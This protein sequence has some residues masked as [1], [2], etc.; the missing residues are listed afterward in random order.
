[1]SKTSV[2]ITCHNYGQYLSWCINSV[3]HQTRKAKEIIVVDDNSDDIT[4]EVAKTFAG[5]I[6]YFKVAFKNSQNARNFGLSQATGEYVLFLDADDFL[7]NYA[8]ETMERELYMNPHL[9]LVYSDKCVFGDPKLIKALNRKFYWKSPEFDIE[10]LKYTNFISLPAL[11][12]KQNF[13]G[14]DERIQ[15]LQD[16]EA[17]LNCLESSAD[18]KRVPQPLFYYRFHG[19]NKTVKA[20]ECIA[21]LKIL[22]KHDLIRVVTGQMANYEGTNVIA[23]PNDLVVVAHNP[24][25]LNGQVFREFILKNRRHIKVFYW[26]G[27]ESKVRDTGALDSLRSAGI[28]CEFFSENNVGRALEILARIHRALIAEADLLLISDFSTMFGGLLES[29][30]EE[31]DMPCVLVFGENNNIMSLQQFEDS[32]LLALNRAG[33]REL[34]Y[35]R[36]YRHENN[37]KRWLLRQLDRHILWRFKPN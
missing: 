32:I 18:A 8:L 4:K 31:P 9:K 10:T 27:E 12:R 22:V 6:R 34:L 30:P 33:V 16:W 24:N 11:I 36:G 15:R 3:I 20:D 35:L 2:I 23:R 14:F 19:E 26:V 17:W 25:R 21:R 5:V 29:M 7:D 28:P 37:V 13:K 1:M